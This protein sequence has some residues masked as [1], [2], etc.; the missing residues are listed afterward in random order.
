MPLYVPI[1][2][3]LAVPLEALLIGTLALWLGCRWLKVPGVNGRRA[4][5]VNGASIGVAIVCQLVVA[6]LLVLTSMIETAGSVA[7]S[8][9]LV[10]VLLGG[11]IASVAAQVIVIARLVGAQKWKAF[12][13]WLFMNATV[14]A[15]NLGLAVVAKTAIVEAFVMPTNAMAPT[16]F[17]VHADRVCSHCGYSFAVGLSQR[18]AP[19]FADAARWAK[20]IRPVVTACPNCRHVDTISV[21]APMRKGDRLLVD[22]QVMPARWE[23]VV[24]RNPEDRKVLFAKRLVGLP[25]ETIEIVAGEVFIDGK[26]LQKPPTVAQDLWLHIHDTA[27]RAKVSAPDDP[28]WRPAEQDS[29]WRAEQGGWTCGGEMRR[30]SLDY[31]GPI[32]DF[33]AYNA[34]ETGYDPESFEQHMV[35]DVLVACDVVSLSGSGRFG[36][37]WKFRGDSVEAYVRPDGAVDLEV[38]SHNDQGERVRDRLSGKLGA[39]L[40]T[41]HR[42]GFAIRD[43]QAYV[44]H[45]ERI[46]LLQPFGPQDVASAKRDADKLA[47]LCRVSLIADKCHVSLNRIVL[48][49]DVYYLAGDNDDGFNFM[50]G[51]RDNP[52]TLGETEYFAL[53]DNSA[54]SKDSRFYGDIQASDLIGTPRWIYWPHRRW[55]AFH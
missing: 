49:R 22:K 36:L 11:L 31:V 28:G 52:V 45:N 35:G 55:H 10:A 1:V 37:Q 13:V 53:G 19:E 5:V 17:G 34:K 29:A 43:G 30:E 6:L 44:V 24:F 21:D 7:T 50:R 48:V 54:L 27:F 18:V 51:G 3:F 8:L 16:I 14:V 2:F 42:L 26:R 9:I 20:R 33:E 23:L 41:G 25:S 4:L 46:V 12:V 38:D 39:P 47:G 40:K 32:D 15:L